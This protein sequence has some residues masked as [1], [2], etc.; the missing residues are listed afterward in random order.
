[1]DTTAIPR[2]WGGG[3]CHATAARTMRSL[4]QHQHVQCERQL[5]GQL[6]EAPTSSGSL[7]RSGSASTLTR[8]QIFDRESCRF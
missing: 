4:L 5:V 2:A 3:R 7:W 1:M 6:R 8:T